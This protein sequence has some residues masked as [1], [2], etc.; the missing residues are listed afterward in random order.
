M[1]EEGLFLSLDE[2]PALPRVEGVDH[3]LEEN[4]G[5]N[6]RYP[7]GLDFNP[8]PQDWWG[9]PRC[10]SVEVLSMKVDLV[11]TGNAETEVALPGE[12]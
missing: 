4:W 1:E 10:D 6:T 5:L 8:F 9:T 3:S 11:L 7:L 12:Q 2:S